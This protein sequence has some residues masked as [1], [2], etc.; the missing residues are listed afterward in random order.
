MKLAVV[1]SSAIVLAAC[2]SPKSTLDDY[3]VVPEFTL[4]A[5]DGHYTVEVLGG[6]AS[7]RIIGAIR[8][9]LFAQ[10]D[11]A[12]LFDV[13]A[14]PQTHV[15]TLT[16]TEKGYCLNGAGALN[17]NHP[18][19]V[20]DLASPELPRSAIGWLMRG[21]SARHA[22]GGAPLT[23]LSCDNL[24]SNGMK[25]HDA[26]MEFAKCTSPQL[27]PW[28]RQSV[29]FPNTLVDCI[30]PASSQAHRARVA[31]A[32]GLVDEASVQ[33]EEFAEW[34]IENKFAGPIPE[35]GK[36]GA[37]IVED[38]EPHQRLKLHIL[39]TCHSALAYMGLP[40]GHEFVRQAI[41]DPE[42]ARFC[43]ALVGEEIAPALAPLDALG[44]WRRIKLRLV[45]PMLDH[46]LMQIAED[47]SAKLAQRVHPLM[48]DGVEH[49]RPIAKL[50]TILR[51]W[52][53]F[54]ARTPSN[55]PQG[56]LLA[57]WAKAGADPAQALDNPSLFP[58]PFRTNATLRSAVLG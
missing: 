14:S 27:L 52:L 5:Q 13:I 9:A 53:S 36:V 41:G 31:R 48:I 51:V 8:R 16:V 35:W 54:M 29:A 49:G 25:L 11:A 38:V 24:S 22:N 30:V 58:A 56:A 21:L 26:T 55:D 23:I 18:D 34:V 28:L 40:R 47:G 1:I 45:N 46:R 10:R 57:Q 32:I 42:L 3:G 33:R 43:D 44:Y 50:G 4:T 7:Y 20:H 2:S 37:E 15:V 12:A 17:L 6:Q 19:I 39:N